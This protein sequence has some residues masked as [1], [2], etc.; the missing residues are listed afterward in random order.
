MLDWRSDPIDGTLP[1]GMFPS[2][3]QVILR[4]KRLVPSLEFLVIDSFAKLIPGGKRYDYSIISPLLMEVQKSCSRHSVAILGIVP[5]QAESNGNGS[6][7]AP[8]DRIFNNAAWGEAATTLCQW[9]FESRNMWQPYRELLVC[10]S[11][12]HPRRFRFE[13]DAAFNITDVTGQLLS[14]EADTVNYVMDEWAKGKQGQQLKT[15]QVHEAAKY[16][17]VSRAS[18]FRWL[19]RCVELGYL[20][21]TGHGEYEVRFPETVL[22]SKPQ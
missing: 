3:E 15:A 14:A 10:P 21:K 19:D 4:A 22:D 16:N 12:Q 20:E 8:R 7:K 13:L 1:P 6:H 2:I 5:M 11:K 18:M 17:S 9:D